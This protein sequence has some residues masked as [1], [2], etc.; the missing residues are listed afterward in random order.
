MKEIDGDGRTVRD[1]LSGRKY[2]VDYYQREYKW[3]TKQV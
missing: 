3:E 1:L 2:S